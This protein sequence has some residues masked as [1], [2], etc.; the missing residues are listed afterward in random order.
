MNRSPHQSW[1]HEPAGAGVPPSIPFVA[2]PGPLNRLVH[3]TLPITPALGAFIGPKQYN[4]M[5]GL[6]MASTAGTCHWVSTAPDGIGTTDVALSSHPKCLPRW[7]R[8]LPTLQEQG[9]AVGATTH[10]AC[11]PSRQDAEYLQSTRTWLNH[12][13]LRFEPVQHAQLTMQHRFHSL[14]RFVL[15]PHL[16]VV[17][18]YSLSFGASVTLGVW[19]NGIVPNQ[20]KSFAPLAFSSPPWGG[21]NTTLPQK[22]KKEDVGGCL[23]PTGTFRPPP[24]WCSVASTKECTR[25]FPL[26]HTHFVVVDAPVV[27]KK[28]KKEWVTTHESCKCY[29]ASS[30]AMV[31]PDATFLRSSTCCSWWTEDCS[32]CFW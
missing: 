20:L 31:E 26:S 10:L 24:S 25:L 17:S 29:A 7:S 5:V 30:L 14:T 19:L 16:Q 11:T 4:A 27:G 23:G 28:K 9:R 8:A 12:T 6:E 21:E 1:N 22:K 13:S 32:E 3:T 18:D 2:M 15:S